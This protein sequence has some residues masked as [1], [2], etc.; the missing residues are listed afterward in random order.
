MNKFI[1]AFDGPWHIGIERQSAQAGHT[2]MVAACSSR[3][4]GGAWGSATWRHEHPPRREDMCK[5]CRKLID[6]GFGE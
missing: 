3:Q 2:Y 5:N 6:R 1:R 4:I